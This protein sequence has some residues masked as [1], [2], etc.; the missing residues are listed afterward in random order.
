M[1][2][3]PTYSRL[4]REEVRLLAAPENEQVQEDWRDMVGALYGVV[5]IYSVTLPR[6]LFYD[7]RTA[8]ARLAETVEKLR[9]TPFYHRAASN[10]RTAEEIWRMWE[11]GG[12]T[13]ELHR[14][15]D[16]FVDELLN[17]SSAVEEYP[18]VPPP[19]RSAAEEGRA[20][21]RR[22]VAGGR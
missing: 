15:A 11:R 19:V 18:D 2:G 1:T 6:P 20:E 22:R 9:G 12:H 4:T 10:A 14:A 3:S 13:D 5:A 8:L 21:L 17:D 7:E 16:A